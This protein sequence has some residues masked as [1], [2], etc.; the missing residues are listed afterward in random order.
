MADSDLKMGRHPLV[1]RAKLALKRQLTPRQ[2]R[3]VKGRIAWIIEHIPGA[4]SRR[5]PAANVP[6]AAP[7][8]LAGDWV[9]VRDWEEVKATLNVWNELRG[10]IFMMEM[11]SYCGTKQRVL[12]PVRQFL[13][14]R[15]YQ[16]KKCR[17]TVLLDG[18][19]CQGMKEYGPCDRSCYF[20]WRTEWLEKTR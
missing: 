15:D 18:V 17:D 11:K 20:F 14:E 16:M 12:K 3:A 1:R 9:S 10:C 8:L 4:A 13:D 5:C 19:I 7:A 6:A 2:K